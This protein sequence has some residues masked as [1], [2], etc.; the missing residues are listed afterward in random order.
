MIMAWPSKAASQLLCALL[1]HL[2]HEVVHAPCI[3]A[4]HRTCEFHQ[5]CF[6]PP[7]HDLKFPV[8]CSPT[9]R[10]LACSP[11]PMLFY[12]PNVPILTWM[13][14]QCS[15]NGL[16]LRGPKVLVHLF[17]SL[18]ALIQHL[19]EVDQ[20]IHTT[21]TFYFGMLSPHASFFSLCWR[22][23][24]TEC[25][26]MLTVIGLCMWNCMFAMEA[27]WICATFARVVNMKV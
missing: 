11:E 9:L 4:P 7:R 8:F 1:S 18:L 25:G 17:Y 20:S 27:K 19:N 21:I 6:P 22:S 10:L 3:V 16:S 2:M 15:K 12:T 24:I 13:A 5:I 26:S 23:P 14:P